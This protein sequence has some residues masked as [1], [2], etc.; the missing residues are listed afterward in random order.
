MIERLKRA[1][2]NKG[3]EEKNRWSE[4]EIEDI[5]AGWREEQKVKEA[6]YVALRGREETTAVIARRDE[7]EDALLRWHKSAPAQGF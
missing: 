3:E 1:K 4:L 7:T 6:T 5:T 2:K